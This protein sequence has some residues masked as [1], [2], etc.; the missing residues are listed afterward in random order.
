MVRGDDQNSR[1]FHNRAPQRF[2]RNQIKALRD[3]FKAWCE[4]EDQVAYFLVD[5]YK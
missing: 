5:Y 4:G 3:L 1:Y 2:R